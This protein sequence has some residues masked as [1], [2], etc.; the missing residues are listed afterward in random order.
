[1]TVLDLILE[2]G[3]PSPLAYF[4]VDKKFMETTG[5]KWAKD[6]TK[7]LSLGLTEEQAKW[8]IRVYEME[9][10]PSGYFTALGGAIAVRYG[11]KGNNILI[12]LDV[13]QRH[14][15]AQGSKM[16]LEKLIK[17]L[18]TEI[19][20]VPQA[21]HGAYQ[22]AKDK[23]E[24]MQTPA[25]LF[26]VKTW[27]TKI[28]GGAWDFTD[29]SMSRSVTGHEAKNL[30]KVLNMTKN[31]VGNYELNRF[32][33]ILSHFETEPDPERANTALIIMLDDV[34]DYLRGDM[35]LVKD[36]V[37]K[38]EGL[39][40]ASSRV[41]M[42]PMPDAK[43][44]SIVFDPSQYYAPRTWV[45]GKW[46]F[47]NQSIGR[48]ITGA[49]AQQL[50]QRFGMVKPTANSKDY[51]ST[52]E[53]HLTLT[54]AFAAGEG[55]DEQTSSIRIGFNIIYGMEWDVAKLKKSVQEINDTLAEAIKTRSTA[56]VIEA[57]T[58]KG[59]VNK[60]IG[61]T[62]MGMK[63]FSLDDADSEFGEEIIKSETGW[64]ERARHKNLGVEALYN[65]NMMVSFTVEKT[66]ITA[67]SKVRIPS[68]VIQVDSQQKMK[69]VDG[70]YS[71]YLARK[72]HSKSDEIVRESYKPAFTHVRF[73]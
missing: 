60:W 69:E 51:Y 52:R 62:Q 71:K 56:S 10:T 45:K 66:E 63:I 34:R 19:G 58:P 23:S 39:I 6:G 20:R 22:E 53:G 72:D 67:R 24:K 2:A 29:Y 7:T 17:E 73:L 41:K 5:K 30:V 46:A 3:K 35:Q 42:A 15:M 61:S 26:K 44:K 28:P 48:N 8:M 57:Y 36:F 9:T 33:V 21:R 1:M 18:E 64:S 59:V 50:V 11:A 14:S 43:Q 12:L 49:E 16:D 40:K 32:F 70:L 4:E 65:K 13:L 55:L 31:S 54:S 38:V 27:V 25:A 47:T 68:C 37:Y